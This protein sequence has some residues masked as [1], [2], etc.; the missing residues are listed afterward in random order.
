M[1]RYDLNTGRPIRVLIVEDSPLYQKILRGILSENDEF[2]VV[3][4]A[5][6]GLEAIK[7]ASLYKPD[8]ISMDIFMP[9]M[10]G[11]E[12]TK[13]IMQSNPV[14]I[15]IVSNVYQTSDTD[16]AIKELDAGAVYIL[17]KPAGPSDPNYSKEASKYRNTLRIMSEIKVVKRSNRSN[18]I[19][20]T[21]TI[22]INSSEEV[23]TLR[24]KIRCTPPKDVKLIAIGASAGGPESLKILL[25]NLSVDVV[26]P[27]VV[28]QHIDPHFIEGFASWLNNY[29]SHKVKVA[30]KGELLEEKIV[31]IA[32]GER[33]MRVDKSMTIIFSDNK[34]SNGHVPSID[35]LFESINEVCG[36]E[37]IAILLSGMGRDGADGLKKLSDSGCYTFAQNEESSLV[38]GMPKE[39]VKLGAACSV[40]SPENIAKEINNMLNKNR[41]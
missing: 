4:V 38:Y 14:P 24:P 23:P 22:L 15:V 2:E 19:S 10:D 5:S 32:P 9:V 28:V 21:N 1:F 12:A 29:S 11:I 6:N 36:K 20:Y 8:I 41:S 18:G 30:T 31:Y 37:C 27:V 26:T 33:H 16:L 34:K 3:A 17:P 39:A 25:S 40:L 13:V 35:V 7:Y